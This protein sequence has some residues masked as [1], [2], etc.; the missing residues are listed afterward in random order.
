MVTNAEEQS[1]YYYRVKSAVGPYTSPYSNEIQVTTNVPDATK[2]TNLSKIELFS[3]QAGIH[4]VGLT[5]ET[6]IT[7]YNLSGI[8]IYQ[9]QHV[10]NKHVIPITQRG[11][12]IIQVKAGNNTEV[13]KIIK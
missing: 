6:S 3:T 7:L 10:L 12:F 4:I 1:D 8:C 9:V 11:I 13:F 5:E 2:T